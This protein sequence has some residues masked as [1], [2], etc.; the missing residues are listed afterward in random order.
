MRNEWFITL[1]DFSNLVYQRVK[2]YI[3]NHYTTHN[4]FYLCTFLLFLILKK[5]PKQ[6]ILNVITKI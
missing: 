3:L 2:V 6:H 5:Y 4:I 1:I